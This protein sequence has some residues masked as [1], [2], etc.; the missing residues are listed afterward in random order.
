MNA[1]W[2]SV[3]LDT[4]PRVARLMGVT[5]RRRQERYFTLPEHRVGSAF[6]AS[7]IWISGLD[8]KERIEQILGKEYATIYKNEAS[9]IP[10]SSS[11]VLDTRL[12]QKVEGLRQRCFT[13]L[14]PPG[15]SH[16]THR[17]FIERIDPL[18]RMP[19]PDPENYAFFSMNP[20]DNRENLTPEYLRVLENLPE[21]QRRRFYEGAYV[22]EI[23]GALW[24]FEMIERVRIEGIDQSLI[25]PIARGDLKDERM[26]SMARVVVAVDPSGTAGDEN[27]RSDAVGIS[28]CGLSSDGKTYVLADRT[29]NLGPAGWAKV[30]ITA[31][32]EFKADR[33]VAEKNFGG[34][35]VEGT[36]RVAD[37]NVPVKMV[38][39]SKGK[40]V[41]AEPISAFYDP[42]IDKVRHVGR[43][44]ELEDQL[45]SF[46]TNGY[47]GDR[48]PDRADALIWALTD[49]LGVAGDGTGFLE[50]MRLEH[51]KMIAAKAEKAAAKA[52]GV[53]QST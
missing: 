36:I 19:L 26:P 34:A 15:K 6:E 9:Q 23:E 29:C 48:S 1:A 12:A 25:A 11:I 37:P 39:A 45:C 50:Y 51:E 18:T 7:E 32:H 2:S 43:M 3:A 16:W 20:D 17:L 42:K 8:E 28:V 13:D 4:L 5:L 35:M 21:R 24:T 53:M 22:D 27:E 47:V 40:A 31:F 14:N 46:S 30:V 38:T 49:L 44:S 33:I 41:R 52:R 10:Y